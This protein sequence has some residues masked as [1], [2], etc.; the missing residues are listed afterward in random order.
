MFTW[1]ELEDDSPAFHPHQWSDYSVTPRAL[2]WRSAR[3]ARSDSGLCYSFAV[4]GTVA[5]Q[6][7][8]SEF[9]S[10]YGHS[11]SVWTVHGF[12][13]PAWVSSRF[14]SPDQDTGWDLELVLGH[15]SWPLLP[16]DGLNAEYQCQICK[17][18]W[19][20]SKYI[21]FYVEHNIYSVAFCLFTLQTCFLL[22]TNKQYNSYITLMQSLK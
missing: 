10:Q 7:E 4:V 16:L 21:V 8:G 11:L 22:A 17:L 6:E 20:T 19:I 5:S 2:T 15:S 14:C 13:M 18:D 1:D 12:L 3:S 9:R